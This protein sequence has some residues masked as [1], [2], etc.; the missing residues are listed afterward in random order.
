MFV[1]NEAMF[2]EER[3]KQMWRILD[4]VKPDGYVLLQEHSF[5]WIA[6]KAEAE[7]DDFTDRSAYID[8]RY[9]VRGLVHHLAQANLLAP[10]PDPVGRGRPCFELSDLGRSPLDESSEDCWEVRAATLDGLASTHSS[11]PALL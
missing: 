6:P 5:Y 9:G 2:K 8:V 1:Y 10:V 7:R 11:I 4:M 3:A